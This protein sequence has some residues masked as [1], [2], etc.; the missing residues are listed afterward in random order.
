VYDRN[1]HNF[2]NDIINNEAQLVDIYDVGMVTLQLML[3]KTE[4][5]PIEKD[6]ILTKGEKMFGSLYSRELIRL[7]IAMIS[8][9]CGLYIYMTQTHKQRIF[10]F[11]VFL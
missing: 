7:V 4:I 6:E 10:L 11:R 3:M 2:V 5:T 1:I 8:N 9:V